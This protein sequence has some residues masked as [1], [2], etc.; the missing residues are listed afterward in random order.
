LGGGRPDRV[1]IF[2]YINSRPLFKEVLGYAVE[3]RTAEDILRCS[4]KIGYDLA[5]VNYGRK[6]FF[7]LG[8]NRYRDEWGTIY[9]KSEVNWP[10]D[11]PIDASVKS[12]EDL[13]HFEWPDPDDAD[14]LDGIRTAVSIGNE[15]RIAVAGSIRGPFSSAWLVLGFE[16]LMV[17]L[18]DDPAFIAEIMDRCVAFY[19]RGAERMV[20]AGVDAVVFTDDYG[21]KQSPFISPE[22]FRLHILPHVAGMVSRIK[23]LGVPIIMHSDGNIAPLLPELVQTGIR[24]YHPVERSAGMSLATVR[25]LFGPSLALLGNVDN[26][27]TLVIGS[28]EDV[29][30]E[31]KECIRAAAPSGGYILSSDHSLHGDIPNENVFALYEAGRRYGVQQP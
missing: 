3:T 14:R 27:T 26:K 31:V 28:I 21:N 15:H 11:A 17:S 22:L 29:E 2:D 30:E 4:V 10:A 6:G 9:E 24:A 18:Y 1:P 13:R 12:R 5:V 20:E 7:K 16:T 8:G 19:V 25:S 23:S